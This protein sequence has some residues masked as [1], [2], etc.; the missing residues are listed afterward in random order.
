M[1]SQSCLRAEAVHGRRSANIVVPQCRFCA[2]PRET[3]VRDL[4]LLDPSAYNF[5]K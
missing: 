3:H 4:I 2:K 5:T 1:I